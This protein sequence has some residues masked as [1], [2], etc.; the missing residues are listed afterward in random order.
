MESVVQ[1]LIGVLEQSRLLRMGLLLPSLSF[2]HSLLRCKSSDHNDACA[3]V[4]P[5][6]GGRLHLL[7]RVLWS[8]GTDSCGPVA[9][10]CC[11]CFAVLPTLWNSCAGSSGELGSDVD[12][13]APQLL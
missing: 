7:R 5:V 11:G 10:E 9:P 4:S 12:C 3:C 1:G 2:A 6:V 13:D 8:A